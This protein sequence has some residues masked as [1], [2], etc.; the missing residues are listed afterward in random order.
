MSEFP[1]IHVAAPLFPL[2]P[3]QTGKELLIDLHVQF[4]ANSAKS[5]LLLRC[6]VQLGVLGH[7]SL[8]LS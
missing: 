5:R 4:L 3:V 7:P 6:R 2:C 8:A 1:L